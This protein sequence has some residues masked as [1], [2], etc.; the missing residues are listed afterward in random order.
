MWLLISAILIA[1]WALTRGRLLLARVPDRR[2]GHRAARPGLVDLR[3]REPPDL[4]V[5][6]RSRERS[7][8][9]LSPPEAMP[10]AD[11]EQEPVEYAEP[12]PGLDRRAKAAVIALAALAAGLGI[13][14]AL[15]LANPPTEKVVV[16]ATSTTTKPK[17][18][19]RPRS[20]PRP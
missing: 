1:I 15:I 13:A 20:P 3:P 10:P 8:A 14:L 19:R 2:L 16:T 6:H 17:R 7:P 12:A 18:R 4:G 5:G 9:P 11:D